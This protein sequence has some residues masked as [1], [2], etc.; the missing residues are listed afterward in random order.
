[1]HEKS[2]ETWYFH[3]SFKTIGHGLWS[4]SRPV[5]VRAL[6]S[7]CAQWDFCVLATIRVSLINT[8][9]DGMIFK[10]SSV[11]LGH[12]I[13]FLLLHVGRNDAEKKN[14]V[15]HI[16]MNLYT[17]I[18]TLLDS[19]IFYSILLLFFFS[20]PIFKIIIRGAF[21]IIAMFV[22]PQITIINKERTIMVPRRPCMLVYTRKWA[23]RKK[24]DKFDTK[25]A[26]VDITQVVNTFHLFLFSLFFLL[27]HS[28][29]GQ[30]CFFNRVK[31]V[32]TRF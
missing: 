13:F 14:I 11:S 3:L 12:S 10:C 16:S 7:L 6:R 28:L 32:H 31:K 17:I 19:Y 22:D 8:F 24:I 20:C 1:M 21:V 4:M 9:I 26:I 30:N 23:A 5:A 29:F 15:C 27:T 25:L 2:L 18:T